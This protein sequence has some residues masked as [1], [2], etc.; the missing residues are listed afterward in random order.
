MILV[1]Y[2]NSENARR[3]LEENVR[4]AFPTSKDFIYEITERKSDESAIESLTAL[5]LL[6]KLLKGIG[7]DAGKL[8]L[9]R[10][11]N[12]RPYFENSS[13]DFS[14]S[15]SHGV[16]AVALSDSGRVGI[17]VESSDMSKERAERLANRYLSVKE[18]SSLSSVEEFLLVWT[19]RE[20]YVKQSGTP[21]TDALKNGISDRVE[22]HRF[23]IFGH[24]A[25]ICYTGKQQIE[26]VT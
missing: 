18:A 8:V 26:I 4:R 23:K 14:I 24:P 21:L 2:T 25:S 19:E 20:A 3:E 1:A 6:A 5:V 13:L 17:D 10:D 9:C 16:V 7:A 12:G 11:K 15:H 22:I